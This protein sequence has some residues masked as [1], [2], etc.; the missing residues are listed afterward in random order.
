MRLADYVCKVGPGNYGRNNYLVTNSGRTLISDLL[1]TRLTGKKPLPSTVVLAVEDHAQLIRA[2]VAIDGSVARLALISSDTSAAELARRFSSLGDYLLVSD[3]GEGSSA[4]SV[5]RLLERYCSTGNADT[6][7]ML[8]TSGTTAESK[9]VAHTLASLVRTVRV[10]EGAG[11]IW[12]QLFEPSRFAGLQVIL[13]AVLGGSGL[14]V[15][16]ADEPISRRVEMLAKESVNAVSATPT[17]WRKI[18]MCDPGSP[19]KLSVVSVGGEIA[20]ARILRTLSE[21]FPGARVRHI[22]ASTEA[23]TGFAVADGLPGFPIEYLQ[24]AP[25]GITLKIA[26]GELLI[27]NTHVDGSYVGS[28]ERFTDVDCYVHTGDKVAIKGDRVVFEGR[29]SG[30]INVGGNKVFPETVE[31]AMLEVDCVDLVRAYAIDSPIVGQLVGLD[32]T[33]KPHC[34]FENARTFLQDAASKE[35]KK[36]ERPVRVRCVE[37]AVITANGK[38][39]RT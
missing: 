11:F 3:A 26:E 29:M 7:W 21:R 24:S 1:T 38:L 18:L 16:D 15:P 28:G 32:V 9:L 2:L 30:V 13:Q 25:N 35:L 14:V 20:D 23:G 37:H 10:G 36:H 22:Y 8:S 19:L 4:V 6:R 27:K 39:D 17:L 34:S 33:L 12:G 31:Q 5:S